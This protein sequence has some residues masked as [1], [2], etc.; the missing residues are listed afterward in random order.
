MLIATFFILNQIYVIFFMIDKCQCWLYITNGYNATLV[1]DLTSVPH[2]ETV[3]CKF[4][5]SNMFIFINVCCYTTSAMVVDE[6]VLHNALRKA[7]CM[8]YYVIICGDFNYN[9]FDQN[10]LHADRESQEF[11]DLILDCFLIQ[12]I[13]EST[14]GENL[15][16]SMLSGLVSTP[17]KGH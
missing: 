14:Q 16:D 17:A 10:T 11:L 12:H 5:L 6:I 1:E 3:W 8:N 9:S 4:I 15:L 2:I 13:R 7:C